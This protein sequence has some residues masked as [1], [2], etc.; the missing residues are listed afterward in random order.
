MRNA[1]IAGDRVYLRPLEVEDA[2]VMAEAS[3]READTFMDRGRNLHSPIAG[4]RQIREMYT[5]QASSESVAF[6]VCLT[7]DDRC[8]GLVDL[9]EID[10]IN[11]VAETGIWLHDSEYRGKGYGTDA[12]HLLLEYAFDRLHLERVVSYVFET[13]LRSAAALKKQGYRPAGRI[14]YHQLKN[15]RFQDMLA[16]DLTREEWT[17]AIKAQGGNHQ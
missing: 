9:D 11:G 4:E 16:F 8:I 1:V 7:V 10:H 15:G 12:K 17:N 13:N 3:H 14:K 6:A 5:G 2:K